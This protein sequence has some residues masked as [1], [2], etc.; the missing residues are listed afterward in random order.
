MTTATTTYKLFI[1]PNSQFNWED[2]GEIYT[3][4]DALREAAKEQKESG[5]MVAYSEDDGE[6]QLLTAHELR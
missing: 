2:F 1:R 5:E 3:D 4:F 6:L